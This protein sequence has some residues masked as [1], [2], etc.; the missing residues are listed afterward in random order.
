[1]KNVKFQLIAVKSKQDSINNVETI[2]STLKKIITDLAHDLD[3][4]KQAKSEKHTIDAINK[5]LRAETLR[6]NRLEEYKQAIEHDPKAGSF[7]YYMQKNKQIDLLDVINDA[8]SIEKLVTLACNNSVNYSLSKSTKTNHTALFSLIENSGSFTY[9]VA[10]LMDHYSSIK[11]S[12]ALAS[13]YDPIDAKNKRE[14]TTRQTQ[15]IVSLFVK[16]GAVRLVGNLKPSNRACQF[17]LNDDSI[18]LQHVA[19]KHK[20]LDV[21]NT[22]VNAE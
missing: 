3:V 19:D 9:S 7:N 20:S 1:M 4:A 12:Q 8:Y 13:G 21:L 14:K 11:E 2:I 6:F 16:L 17:T 22:F 5:S 18:L 10:Q 15:M